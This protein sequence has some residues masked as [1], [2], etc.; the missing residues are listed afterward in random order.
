MN[1]A[2]NFG[3]LLAQ[4]ELEAGLAHPSY[5]QSTISIPHDIHTAISAL[6]IEPK[7]LRSI[8]CPKCFSKYSLESLPQVCLRRET[9]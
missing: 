5:S 2:I 1:I 4:S 6:S 8:C 7:I 9:P 3:G